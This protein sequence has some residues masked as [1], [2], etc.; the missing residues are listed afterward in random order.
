MWRQGQGEVIASAR[1]ASS[2][3]AVGGSLHHARVLSCRRAVLSTLLTPPPRCTHPILESIISPRRACKIGASK[4]RPGHG[5]NQ[6]ATCLVTA[7][8]PKRRS[9]C[10]G[11][12]CKLH[13][14]HCDKDGVVQAASCDGISAARRAWE[15]RRRSGTPWP[16]GH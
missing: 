5:A 16:A 11:K 2:E 6:H 3:A 12:H 15:W 8:F 1:A 13:G 4:A 14:R 10:G 7:P 9:Q